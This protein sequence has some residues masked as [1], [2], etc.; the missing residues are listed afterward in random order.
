MNPEHSP[1]NFTEAEVRRRLRQWADVTALSLS[2]MHSA[3]QWEF[4]HLSLAEVRAKLNERLATHRE[5]RLPK[6]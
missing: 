2:L 3:I 1:V 5:R 4:P 6:E